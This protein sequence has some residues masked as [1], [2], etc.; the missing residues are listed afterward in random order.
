MATLIDEIKKDKD[1]AL[2]NHEEAKDKLKE[3]EEG[4]DGQWL[5]ELKRKMRRKEFD[6]EDKEEKRKLEEEKKRLEKKVDDWDE[7]VRKLQNKLA[8]FGKGEE[9]NEQIA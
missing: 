1:I 3:F 9:G 8:N 5:K 2:K 4:E 6:E 7:Q